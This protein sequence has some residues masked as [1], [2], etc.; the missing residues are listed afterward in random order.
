M[1]TEGAKTMKRRHLGGFTL[2]E[3]LVVIAIIAILAA[4]LFPVFAQAREKA[5]QISCLSNTKQVGLSLMMYAQ[6]YDERLV[7]NNDQTWRPDGSLYTWI[8]LMSPY[9]KN[10]QVWTCPSASANNGLYTSYGNTSSAYVL[11]NLYWYDGSLGQLFEQSSGPSSLA[12]IDE[13]ART[14]FTSDGGGVPDHTVDGTAHHG[15]W[16]DPE[17]LVW[18]GGV[19]VE[20]TAKPYPMIHC[21]YQG[22]IVGRHNEGASV[23]WLDGHSKFMKISGLGKMNKAGQLIY[24]IKSGD[25]AE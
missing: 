4:I 5:R 6:D 11:N 12:A 13:P 25:K 23:A 14:V 24:F 21:V 16:W 9:I 17:Q 1:L 3:L 20:P 7:L 2:I 15:T 19:Y 8:E 10:K 18:D 22:G